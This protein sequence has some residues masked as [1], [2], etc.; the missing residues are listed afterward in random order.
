MNYYKATLCA[1]F[2]RLSNTQLARYEGLELGPAFPNLTKEGRAEFLRCRKHYS[3][4]RHERNIWVHDFEDATLDRAMKALEGHVH[5]SVLAAMEVNKDAITNQGSK[6]NDGNQAIIDARARALHAS[7][8]PKSERTASTSGPPPPRKEITATPE[9]PITP[10]DPRRSRNKRKIAAPQATSNTPSGPR[11][12]RKRRKTAA[13]RETS[14]A[15]PRR[16]RRR[17][18]AKP[19]TTPPTTDAVAS[20]HSSSNPPVETPRW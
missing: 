2:S 15:R 11:R 18:K 8:M 6:F 12:P 14:N 10:S 5:P 9:T 17:Q 3:R 4:L 19:K 16:R 20:R 13:T 1:A 7:S